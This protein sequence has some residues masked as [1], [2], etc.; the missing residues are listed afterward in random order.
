LCGH[1]SQ[2]TF[3]FTYLFFGFFYNFRKIV[4]IIHIFYLF[5]QR[6]IFSFI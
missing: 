3:A 6:K 4:W 1:P 2:R 5:L